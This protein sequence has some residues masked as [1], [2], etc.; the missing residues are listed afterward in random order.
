MQKNLK[1]ELKPENESIN[2]IGCKAF[3][4]QYSFARA[5]ALITL[6]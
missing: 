5:Y 1:L 4:L 6:H 3:Q 2:D